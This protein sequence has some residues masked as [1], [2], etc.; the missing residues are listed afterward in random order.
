MTLCLIQRILYFT[1]SIG[2]YK[3]QL[4]TGEDV[5]NLERPHVSCFK[6]EFPKNLKRLVK[7][8]S[9]NLCYNN[10]ELFPIQISNLINLKI[11]RLTNLKVCELNSNNIEILPE[12]I[13]YLQSLKNALLKI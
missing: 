2:K 8:E 1:I 7:L 11:L 3:K 4:N 9:I 13:R 5:Y 6:F 10:I 12:E